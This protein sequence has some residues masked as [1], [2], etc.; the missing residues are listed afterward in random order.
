MRNKKEKGHSNDLTDSLYKTI[1]VLGSSAVGKTS[2]LSQLTKSQF[3]KKH[4][5]TIGLDYYHKIVDIPNTPHSV[6]LSLWDTSGDEKNLSLL[7]SKQYFKSNA[8]LIVCSYDNI[9]SYE[10]LIEWITFIRTQREKSNNIFVNRT[11]NT[12]IVIINKSDIKNKKF[13]KKDVYSLVHSC[14]PTV[15]ISEMN[16]NNTNKVHVLFDKLIKILLL[17]ENR[18][19]IKSLKLEKKGMNV[20]S[21]KLFGDTNTDDNFNMCNNSIMIDNNVNKKCKS[22]C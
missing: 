4:T 3:N 16:A 8:F 5:S 1:I 11:L 14:F 13:T 9:E 15:F 7:P 10:K 2:I 21:L 18:D 17:K 19:F 12:T 22:C 6:N 20:N